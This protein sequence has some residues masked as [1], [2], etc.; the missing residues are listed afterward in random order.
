MTMISYAQNFEDVMLM[1]ALRH[2]RNGFYVDV[3]AQHP[4][5]GSVTKAFHERG[6]QGINIEPVQ[7]WFEMVCADR[8]GDVNLAV[9]I[10]EKP[11]IVELFDVEDTGLSTLRGDYAG[12]HE[13]SGR[14]VEIRRLKAHRLSSVFRAYAPRDVHFLKIDVEGMEA[15]VVRS[16]DLGRY[17]PWIIVVEATKPNSP[18]PSFAEWEPIL[19]DS[20]YTMVYDDGLNRFYVAGEHAELAKSFDRPPNFFDRFTVYGEYWAGLQM[21]RM[22][23][24]LEASRQQLASERAA[25]DITLA[26]QREAAS[27]LLE[28]ER[29]EARLLLETEQRDALRTLSAEREMAR[30]AVQAEREAG[31]SA[32]ESE[33]EA[34]RQIL[35]SERDVSRQ[36]LEIERA[37]ARHHLEDAHE[38]LIR[39]VAEE[40]EHVV[41]MFR[42]F[43]QQR[44]DD[45][46]TATMS[47]IDALAVELG[48]RM[49]LVGDSASMERAQFTNRESGIEDRVGAIEGQIAAVHERLAFADNVHAAFLATLDRE[50]EIRAQLDE[51]TRSH[52]WRM[53]K[54]FRWI[55][56]RLGAMVPR[57]ISPDQKQAA[58]RGIRALARVP[59][60]RRLASVAL[61]ATPGVK[62]RLVRVVEPAV[63][64]Q[65][66]APVVVEAALPRRAQLIRDMLGRQ[67]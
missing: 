17:R 56:R 1:R 19:L 47:R 46:W 45:Q 34:S 49:D 42:R 26:S 58:A 61:R 23:S 57:G 51:I 40:R 13:A 25:A 16:L 11:G 60:L 31:R 62:A 9:P 53:T 18:E 64:E 52:S 10:C 5:N 29:G 67:R 20:G 37:A 39:A 48:R 14:H 3:G 2:V 35:E 24:E 43:D 38:K 55:R 6:W 15:S 27:A 59:L 28:S 41:D 30:Q 8:P 44:F 36:L 54:G 33:R 22:E 32:L 63:V 50:R 7:R 4:I 65:R 12:E 21:E 66:P